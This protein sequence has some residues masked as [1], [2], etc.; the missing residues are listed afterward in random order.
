MY[1]NE[2]YACVQDTKR[3]VARFSRIQEKKYL[4]KQNFP[5]KRSNT[6]MSKYNTIQ[7]VRNLYF[8]E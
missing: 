3:A 7:L 1:K 5:L 8:Y 4:T 2:P 6:H